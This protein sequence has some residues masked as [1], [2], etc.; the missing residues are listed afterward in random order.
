[1]RRV[2]YHGNSPSRKRAARADC[3]CLKKVCGARALRDPSLM[4]KED[5]VADAPRLAEVV[6]DQHD[7]GTRGD[8]RQRSPFSTSCVAPGSR[9]AVGSSR[10]MISGCNA[11]ARA[12]AR[13][14][15]SPPERTRAGCARVPLEAHLGQRLART[16]RADPG[17]NAGDAERV[18][19]V[20]QRRA[21]QQHRPLKHHRLPPR[22]PGG[23]AEFQTIE[24]EVGASRA[25]TQAKQYALAGCRWARR[26][27]CAAR[28]RSPTTASSMMRRPPAVNV[29][30]VETQRQERHRRPH[31]HRLSP[32]APLR[33]SL[34]R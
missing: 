12:S 8:H 18:R 14:C 30:C 29:T 24:P 16:L 6:G 2:H 15:C 3:G 28:H 4:Q 19:D 20:G 11:Q 23:S 9:L 26:S 31:V 32:V 13:R 27:R 21:A 33:V 7:L 5:L 17:R 25:M 1:M 10:K 22:R 34:T